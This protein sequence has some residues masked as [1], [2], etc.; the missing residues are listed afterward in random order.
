MFFKQEYPYPD[1][2]CKLITGK[3]TTSVELTL[4][5]YVCQHLIFIFVY[6][7]CQFI[8]RFDFVYNIHL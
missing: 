7:L 1:I 2:K 8:Q 3:F 4:Q 5:E 6:L